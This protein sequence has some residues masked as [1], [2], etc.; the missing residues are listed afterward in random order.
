[1]TRRALIGVRAAAWHAGSTFYVAAIN[2]S[3]TNAV[4]ATVRVPDLAG[5]TL[6]VLGEGRQVA[7]SGNGLTDAFALLQVHLCTSHVPRAPR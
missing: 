2:P 4:R 7:V 5:R 1:M 3:A 6:D